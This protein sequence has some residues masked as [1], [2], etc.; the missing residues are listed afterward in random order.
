MFQIMMHFA[1][2]YDLLLFGFSI[3][4]IV[5]AIVLSARRSSRTDRILRQYA[6]MLN[7]MSQGICMF[8]AAQRLVFCNNRY[9]EMYD[10][11]H[12]NVGPGMELSKIIDLRYKAGSS[13]KM[14]QDQYNIWRASINSSQNKSE[15]IVELMNGRIAEIRHQPLTEG[16]YV[17]THEDITTRQLEARQRTAVLEQEKRRVVV[18][19]AINSLRET[20]ETLLGTVGEDTIA[21]KNTAMLLSS[22]SNQTSRYIAGA[23]QTADEASTSVESASSSVVELSASISSIAEQL[24][25]TSGLV[26]S[27][28]KEANAADSEIAE[29]TQSV[30]MIGEIVKIIG[31]I[32]AQTNLLAL[33]AT[34][35]AARAGEYGKG[36]AVVA[37]EVKSLAAQ[38]AKAT[39]QIAAQIAAVQI[40]SKS[41]VDAIHRNAGRVD[42]ISRHTSAV[43]ACVEEQNAA[44]QDISCNVTCATKGT[45]SI[46][47]TLIEVN[48][49]ASETRDSAQIVL[50]AS[51]RVEMAARQLHEKIVGFLGQVAV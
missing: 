11:Q 44:T 12:E 2:E 35:E 29:L 24:R 5:L 34:I 49:A 28:V 26:N 8:D 14:S 1:T 42:E 40:S 27:S 22:S 36:F 39:E 30:G 17:A 6:S 50:T 43:V 7:N 48:R 51:N 38:T 32:A 9:L 31:T 45:Q 47:A 10:I 20:V 46:R 3:F 19:D 33:N 15:T 23:V 21:L 18:D 13:P 16:G 4:S 37:S 25:S 41:A